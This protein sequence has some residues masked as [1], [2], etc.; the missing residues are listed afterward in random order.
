LIHGK[1]IYNLKVL[2]LKRIGRII[3]KQGSSER[4]FVSQIRSSHVERYPWPT[5][6]WL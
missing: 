4:R 5:S 2:F 1:Y 3:S 6:Y